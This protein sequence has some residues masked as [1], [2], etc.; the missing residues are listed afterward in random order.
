[1][2][3]AGKVAVVTGSGRGLGR[4]YAE[5]LARG[6]GRGRRQRRAGRD[7]GRRRRGDRA[8]GGTATGVV[9]PVGSTE[10]ADRLVARRGRRL[11][12]ARRDGHQRRHPARPGAVEDVAT[13][14]STPSS[15]VHLRGTF[16]CARA[17][18]VRMREQ[19]EGGR[20]VAGLLAG[21]PARQLRADQL[22]GGQGGHRRVG[23]H[24]GDGAGQVRHRRQRDRPGRRHRDDQDHPGL[25][26]GDRGGRADRQRRSRMAAQGRGLRHRRGRAALVVF[27]A[28]D[29]AK[30]V[31]GQ[32]I[33]IGG[34]RLAL[35]SHPSEKAVAFRGRRLERRRDRRRRGHSSLGAARRDATASRRRRCP[36]RE[37]PARPRRDHR[38]R[39]AHPR[40]GLA[41]TATARSARSC[42]DASADVLQGARAPAARRI[43]EIAAYYR[44]RQ[45]ARRRL[46]RR[47][48]ARHRAGRGSPTP[49]SPRTARDTPTC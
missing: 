25:R 43:D 29:A 26:P 17:A 14:T 39:R 48:R 7:R 49:R 27:L 40:R 15:S 37:R 3:L 22:R 11:R 42:S 18:A 34:D 33:G 35:W 38:D 1:M 16:T 9:A 36:S 32:A 4:A 6:R 12:A 19:G 23:P 5:A 2:D 41:P 45:M 31:T 46:H 21:R 24:L 8:A 30:G 20:I 44:E 10:T 28:S 13:T 47:R